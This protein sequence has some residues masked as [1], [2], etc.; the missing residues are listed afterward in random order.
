MTRKFLSLALASILSCGIA[1][2]AD[3]NYTT[4]G[5]EK[6]TRNG[7]TLY[8]EANSPHK[9]KNSEWRF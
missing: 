7:L 2:G 5:K 8:V 9:Q 4:E 6:I 3:S 1:F